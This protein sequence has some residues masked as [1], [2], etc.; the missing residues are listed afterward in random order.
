M[1]KYDIVTAKKY[2]KNGEEKT[3]WN[4][5]GSLVFFPANGD[6]KEGYALELSMYPETKFMVFEKKSVVGK[7]VESGQTDSLDF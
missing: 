5:V 6:K 1:K 2:T 3:Q 4:N 7:V